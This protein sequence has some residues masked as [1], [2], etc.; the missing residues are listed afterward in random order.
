MS[1]SSEA[2]ETL[3]KQIIMCI[4]RWPKIK[5]VRDPSR[6]E[7]LDYVHCQQEKLLLEE[8]L[9][10]EEKRKLLNRIVEALVNIINKEGVRGGSCFL[11]VA[12][13][14]KRINSAE[15]MQAIIEIDEEMGDFF[16]KIGLNDGNRG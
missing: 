13:Y 4:A 1:I 6:F 2:M 9:L 8:L 12:E 15:N 14:R 16:N 10:T 7:E 3:K 11:E 5:E